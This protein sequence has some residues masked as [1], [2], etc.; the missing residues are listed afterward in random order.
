[1]AYAVTQ[2]C[3]NDATCVSVCPVNC[4]HPTPEERAA[5]AAGGYA[6]SEMVFIDPVGCIDCGACVDA[7]PVGAITPVDLLRGP[8]TVFAD[9][10]RDYYA[11]HPE[12]AT[13]DALTFPTTV[14]QGSGDLHVAIVGTGPSAAYAA[15]ALLTGTPATLTMIDRLPV[16][17]GLLRSGVAPDHPDTKRIEDTFAWTYAHPRVTVALNVDVGRDVTHE[18]LLEH[19]H[20][21]VYAVGASADRRLGIP[22][23]DLAGSVPASELVAWYNAQPD[24]V[25][26]EIDLSVERVVVVGNGNVALDVARVLLT[27]PDELSRTDIADDALAALRRSRVREVVV[28]GRRGPADAAFTMSELVGMRTIDG[29]DLVVEEHPD[30]AAA[31]DAAPVGSKAAMLRDVE[32]VSIDWDAPPAPG[33]RVVLAFWTAPVAVEGADRVEAVRVTGGRTIAAGALVRSIGYRGSPLPG[34]PFDPGTATVPN[35]QGRVLDAD[36]EPLPGAYVVGWIKRGATGGIGANRACAQETV[37]AIVDD[38]SAGRL[39]EPTGSPRALRELLRRRND[40]VVGLRWMRSIDRAERL[41][42]AAHGR[43]RRKFATVPELL[44]AG[45]PGRWR[46]RRR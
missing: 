41:G 36:G 42:G 27:D 17:G 31:V 30:A 29:V 5:G 34:L 38:V 46:S 8:D 4:I 22:G 28:L 9:L 25:A 45:S 16:A 2:S 1:M 43:P 18:E 7:C 15:R 32:R 23:E 37:A 39:A 26:T 40:D 3:C 35:A 14:P 21:V 12:S 24:R 6:S 33:K 10:N 13:W 44:A 20:A 11:A 19:H